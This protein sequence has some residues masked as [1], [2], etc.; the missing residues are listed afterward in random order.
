MLTLLEIQEKNKIITAGMKADGAMIDMEQ[1]IPCIMHAENRC[2][3][4]S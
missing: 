3:E 2:G 1:A 4:K